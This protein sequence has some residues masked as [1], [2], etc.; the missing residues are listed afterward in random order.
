MAMYR[1]KCGFCGWKTKPRYSIIDCVKEKEW[2]HRYGVK[3]AGCDA[4][5]SAFGNTCPKCGKTTQEEHRWFSDKELAEM[6]S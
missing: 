6:E 1:I 3:E 5:D 2:A 4:H